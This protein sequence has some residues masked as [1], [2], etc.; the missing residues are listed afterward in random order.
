VVRGRR[1]GYG[2]NLSSA[3]DRRS[4]KR[5]LNRWSFAYTG[6]IRVQRTPNG[7]QNVGWGSSPSAPARSTTLQAHGT[8]RSVENGRP[9]QADRNSSGT[10]AVASG[11]APLWTTDAPHTE[12]S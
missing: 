10:A 8:Y 2:S 11:P 3:A 6:P 7:L 5:F 1:I 9:S 4:R 12:R